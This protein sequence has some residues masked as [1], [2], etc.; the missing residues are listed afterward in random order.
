MK[1]P[2]GASLPGGSSPGRG[3]GEVFVWAHR[4]ASALAPENTLASFLLASE[5][6]ADG[7]ELDVQLSADGIPV[8]LHDPFLWADGRDIVLRPAPLQRHRMRPVWVAT[9]SWDDL[10]G[11]PV[12]FPD[13]SAAKLWR[14]E[15]VLEALPPDL[16]AD[17]ELKA[18]ALYDPRLVSVVVRCASQRPGRA[19]LSSFDHVAL[20]EV[21]VAAPGLPLMAILHARPVELRSL[22]SSIP[23]SMASIDRPFLTR[24]DVERWRSDGIEVSVGGADLVEDIAQ[25]LSWP[26]AGVF[27][28]DPRLAIGGGT[29]GA[30]EASSPAGPRPGCP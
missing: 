2:A 14:L 18:G 11:R 29:K 9:C 19:V 7:V 26:I 8:V 10:V 5:L 23:T 3:P 4:G 21:A 28:D 16:W 20:K 17:I 27:L 25:V 24:A 13:G 15:E 6:G 22:L 12:I 1:P 30:A